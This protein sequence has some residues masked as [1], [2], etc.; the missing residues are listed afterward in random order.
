MD[1]F[2][3]AVKIL[4]LVAVGFALWL[5]VRLGP[6]ILAQSDEEGTTSASGIGCY[7]A[8]VFCLLWA[9]IAIAKC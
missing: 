7:L 9:L 8:V 2:L 5:A 4:C 3:Y 1:S 6:D